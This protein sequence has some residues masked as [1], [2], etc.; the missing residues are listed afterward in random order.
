MDKRCVVVT[1]ASGSLGQVVVARLRDAGATVVPLTRKDADLGNEAQVEAAYDAALKAHGAI[2]GSVHCAGG[3]VGSPFAQTAVEVFEQMIAVN[4][5]SAFLC[6]RAAL[7]RMRG[8]G[9]IVNVAALNA[10]T[11]TGVRG[12]AAYAASKAGVIALTK[13]IAEEGSGVHANCVAPGMMRTPKNGDAP[14][15]VPLEDVAEA[16]VY[17]V[18]PE[19]GALNGA[20]LTFP[21][22]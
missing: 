18:S 5:R 2:W 16:I 14:G 21:S 11:L 13:A 8:E 22:R 1:G 7:R 17:L 19:A 6:C 9:R 3:W 15:Q 12:S 20:V 10:A 4:L